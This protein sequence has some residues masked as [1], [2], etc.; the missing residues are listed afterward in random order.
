MVI[1]PCQITC[2]RHAQP[3]RKRRAGMPGAV[4]IVRRFAALAEAGDAAVL[5]QGMEIRSAAS[6]QL[7]NVALVGNI[8]QELISRCIKYAVQGNA[9]LHH[10]QVGGQVATRLR[11]GMNEC[12][13]NLSR[14]H[15]E[16]VGR[17]IFHIQGRAYARQQWRQLR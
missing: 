3:G 5:A 4:G 17:Q 12:A 8:K 11:Q 2:S 6:Q 10:A 13:A 7:V 9:Q 14:K 1:I 15:I 16:L